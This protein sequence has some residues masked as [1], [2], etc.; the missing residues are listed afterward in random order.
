MLELFNQFLLFLTPFILGVNIFIAIYFI[1]Y[2]FIQKLLFNK[3]FGAVLLILSTALIGIMLSLYK[4]NI[5]VDIDTLAFAI[6]YLYSLYL[7]NKR[8]TKINYLI[9]IP[10]LL[11][12]ILLITSIFSAGIISKEIIKL[13]A[14]INVIYSTIL[15][16]FSILRIKKFQKSSQD[17]FAIKDDFT[18]V[19]LILVIT[20]IFNLLWMA[21]EYLLIR[22]YD[23]HSFVD[24]MMQLI[25]YGVILYVSVWGLNRRSKE[26]IYN[27]MEENVRDV[28]ENSVSAIQYDIDIYNQLYKEVEQKQ[29]Y[30]NPNVSLK[31]VA[32]AI[33]QKEKIVSQHINH[34]YN[35]NFYSFINS[36]RVSYFKMLIA[37]DKNAEISIDGLIEMCGFKSKSTFYSHF[38]RI[39]GCTPT[40]FIKNVSA[41]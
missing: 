19:L 4:Y 1:T 25:S 24:I 15:I 29:L 30:L 16:V 18:G 23:I 3:V 12:I 11:Q 22:F 2:G 13:I 10:S 31:E 38:K 14:I 26:Q 20:L 41:S 7:T 35:N 17:Y 40:Q 37:E 28:I 34:F 9:F 27:K 36:F 21:N 33:N 5:Y 32:Q 8:I 39:E 6:L